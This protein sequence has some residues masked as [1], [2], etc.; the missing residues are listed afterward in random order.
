MSF[1]RYKRNLYPL[2]AV[3]SCLFI[4]VFGF[5]MAK[6]IEF[7]YYLC[8]LFVW[9]ILFG[10]AKACLKVLPIAVLI[11]GIFSCISYFSSGGDFNAALAMINRFG[12]LFLALVPGMS[13]E[14]VAM[15][16]NLSQIKTPRALTLGMLIVMSF[17]PVLKSEV[18]RVREA[19]KTRGAGSVMNPKIMYRAF[20]IPMV[21]R[22]VDISDTLALSIETRGF[23]LDGSAYT[24]YKK[25]PICMS[26]AVYIAGIL[27]GA[28]LAMIL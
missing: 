16:R 25:E 26:D 24:V 17:T 19:M 1:F 13:V 9:L 18:R 5:I 12:A 7:T 27:A 21:T 23:V 2:F 22:I 6:K 28:G 20:L 3:F 14:P 8:G 4:L 11:G 10:C 15:T